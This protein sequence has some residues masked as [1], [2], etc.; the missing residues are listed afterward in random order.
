MA[1]NSHSIEKNEKL[2]TQ[3]SSITVNYLKNLGKSGLDN[4][5]LYEFIKY[6]ETDLLLVMSRLLV[7]KLQ[8]IKV[9]QFCLETKET[10]CN[11]ALLIAMLL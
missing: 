8:V 6:A 2:D 5:E 7:V 11:V 3:M 10:L 9:K 1:G 4:S